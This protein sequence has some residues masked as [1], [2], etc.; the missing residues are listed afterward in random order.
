[1]EDGYYYETVEF[2]Q[3]S[4][5]TISDNLVYGYESVNNFI[6]EYDPI[7]FPV[8]QAGVHDTSGSGGGGGNG[9]GSC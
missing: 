9:G 7:K 3:H 8:V 6:K 4:L 2:L 1:M 5:E